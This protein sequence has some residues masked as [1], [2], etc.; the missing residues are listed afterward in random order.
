MFSDAD[1]RVFESGELIPLEEF[2]VNRTVPDS[3]SSGTFTE[4]GS[5]GDRAGTVDIR[6]INSY[7]NLTNT[8]YF[9]LVGT[10]NANGATGGASYRLYNLTDSEVATDSVTVTG[11]TNDPFHTP[12][13]EYTPTTEL[14]KYVVQARSE[15]GTTS[16]DLT[17]CPQVVVWGEIA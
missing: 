16:I 17:G 7:T 13:T 5:S 14:S 12:R 2:D 9:E 1:K 15:D 6:H 3:T 8:L 4:M 11:T 10:G